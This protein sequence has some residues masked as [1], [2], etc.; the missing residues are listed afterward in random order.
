MV[1]PAEDATGGTDS[2]RYTK[3][4]RETLAPDQVEALFLR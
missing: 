2:D 1:V 4:H 3:L